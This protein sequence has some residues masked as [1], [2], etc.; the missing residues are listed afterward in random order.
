MSVGI[1]QVSFFFKTSK[2]SFAFLR[3]KFLR[4]ISLCFLCILER[5]TPP[6]SSFPE[7][8]SCCL[9]SNNSSE[10]EAQDNSKF[11]KCSILFN[12]AL[13]APITSILNG[14][15]PVTFSPFSLA[16]FVTSLNCSGVNIS[17]ALRK[18]TFKL[19]NSIILLVT[20]STVFNPTD[21][22]G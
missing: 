22:G 16:S 13:E 15:W 6:L 18:S 17:Y 7:A 5:N 14:T 10:L 8:N 9:S 11:L 1:C 19:S 12:P 2:T 21:K 3:S 4:A 20:S